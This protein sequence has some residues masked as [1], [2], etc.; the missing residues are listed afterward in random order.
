M[1]KLLPITTALLLSA[2]P[3]W[4]AD[5]R[6]ADWFYNPFSKDSAY[7]RPIGTGADYAG[8]DHPAV[9]DWLTGS[10]FNINP[11]DRPWGC[12]IWESKSGDPLFTVTYGSLWALPPVDKSGPDLSKLGLSEK[13]RRLAECIRDYGIYVVDGGG[14]TALRADQDFTPEL[15]KDLKAESAK[16]YRY[17][18]L[19]KNSVP[20]HGKVVFR[21]GDSATRPTGGPNRQIVPGEFPAGGGRPLAPNTAVDAR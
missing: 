10:A 14:A 15:T 21:V 12:G 6:S 9:I 2:W 19:V 1:K 8:A 4:P 17:I 7:H 11:G 16:F 20:E 3:L 5:P 18:R 13:G